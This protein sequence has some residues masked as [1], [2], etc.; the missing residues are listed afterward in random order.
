MR[1]TLISLRHRATSWDSKTI[2][3]STNP[4]Y[5]A[6]IS[7]YA[8]SQSQ[9]HWDIAN[10]FE[11]MWM[12]GDDKEEQELVDVEGDVGDSVHDDR[13]GDQRSDGRH[14]D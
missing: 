14:V 4:Q 7:A 10:A 8:Q 5:E 9:L 1:R 6:G 11:L 13:D 3:T 2:P 12:R